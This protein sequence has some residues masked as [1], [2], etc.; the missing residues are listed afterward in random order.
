MC[1]DA[2]TGSFGFGPNR[3]FYQKDGGRRRDRE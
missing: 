2:G 1:E 3:I